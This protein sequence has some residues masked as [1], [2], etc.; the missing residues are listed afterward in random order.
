MYDLG[1]GSAIYEDSALQRCFRDARAATAHFQV[2]P[3]SMRREDPAAGH[4]PA[5]RR[6]LPHG[7][8]ASNATQQ[9]AAV[10]AAML[11]GERSAQTTSLPLIVGLG[12]A[13]VELFSA[14]AL[15]LPM[16]SPSRTERTDRASALIEA[17]RGCDGLI[18]ASP[19]YHGNL[20]GLLKN[21]LDYLEDLRADPRPYLEGRAVGCIACAS[22]WQGTVA[23]LSS[24]RS[25]VH[26]LRGW[27]TPLGVTV[28]T[29]DPITDGDGVVDAEIGEKLQALG[30][31][32][33]DFARARHR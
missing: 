12:G 11:G 1:G 29:A 16:Y 18:L 4:H 10:S 6:G 8:A 31:Q 21:A 25:I 33:L 27:P 17:V 5:P 28:N 3:A 23:T 26:A 24:L 2:N 20:S 7:K 13:R 9:Q 22:G 32:V 15:D 14:D 19:S 30:A